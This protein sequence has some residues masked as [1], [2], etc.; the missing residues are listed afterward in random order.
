MSEITQ[1]E[2]DAIAEEAKEDFD[3][4]ADLKGVAAG[5]KPTHVRVYTDEDTGEEIGG[6]EISKN[7]FGVQT[8]I[9]RWGILGE[10]DELEANNVDGNNTKAIAALKRKLPALRKKLEQSAIDITLVKLPPVIRRS[11]VRL[12]KVALDIKGKIPADRQDDFEAQNLAELLALSCTGYVDHA[13]NR[14]T[15][16]LTVKNA[17]ALRDYLPDSE[18]AKVVNAVSSLQFK[19][20]ISEA[21]TESADFSQGI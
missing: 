12:A 5:R 19:A 7:A 4:E 20:V 15:N 21:A 17:I 8:D 2:V 9:D 6:V 16:G 14:R 1:D 13:R 18:Y 10:I 11:S 3:L